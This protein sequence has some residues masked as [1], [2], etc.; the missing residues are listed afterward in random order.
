MH[1]SN[2]PGSKDNPED[3]WNNIKENLQ[4]ACETVLDQQ[5]RNKIRPW[6]SD[7]IL[8]T[9][10]ERLRTKLSQEPERYAELYRTIKRKC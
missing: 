4:H 5:E 7:E 1:R 3:I 10:E 6:M 2:D 9:M 8:D